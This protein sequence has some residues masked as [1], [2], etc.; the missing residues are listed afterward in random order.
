M[1]EPSMIATGISGRL[2]VMMAVCCALAVSNIDYLHF[3]HC[4]PA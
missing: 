3:H 4:L 1:S 2:I